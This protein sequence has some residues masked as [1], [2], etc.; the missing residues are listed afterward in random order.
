MAY[1]NLT[2]ASCK[3]HTALDSM[4]G[5]EMTTNIRRTTTNLWDDTVKMLCDSLGA[6]GILCYSGSKAEGLR[7]ES[8]D[9]D[10]MFIYRDIKVIPSDSYITLYN[11]NT[12]LLLM[13]N[14]M[15]KMGFTLL[16]LTGGT[17]KPEVTRSIEYL[18][19]RPYLS[20]TR[21]K[22][23]HTENAHCFGSGIY[24]RA[25]CKCCDR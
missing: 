22:E 17:T 4:I 1:D 12:T 5:C 6:N 8:S 18:F 16:R 11:S 10:W 7:F 20:C 19:N 23:F 14:E 3:L 25:L 9:D 21:W 24:T 15:T 13:E 2:Q